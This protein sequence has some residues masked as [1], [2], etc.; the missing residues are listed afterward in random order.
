MKYDICIVGSGAGAAPVAYTLSEQ[1][2][3][4]AVLEK[5]P[6]LREEDFV[7]DEIAITRRPLYTPRLSEE[8]HVVETYNEAG[9]IE[10]VTGEESGWNFWNGSMV[11]GSSN[12]MS[13]YFHRM[14]PADFRLKSEYGS[15]EGANVVDWP[16]SYEEMEPYYTKVEAVVGVSGRVVPHP[17]LEPRSTK[18]FP[19]EPTWEQP[20]SRWF[21]EACGTLGFSALP[22]PRAVLPRDAL[23]RSGCSY[24]NYCGSYGCATGAKG[25]ARAA[26]LEKALKNGNC[27]I[28]PDA[29]V[30]RLD[31][32]S[33][34]RV[35][36][37]RYYDKKGVPHAV[38]ARLFVVAA[39]AIESA[40]L[41]LNSKSPAFPDG[42]A[43][44]SGQ[45]GKNLIF[46]AGG[47]GSGRFHLK[48]LSPE[49]QKGLMQRGAFVNR[50]LQDWYAFD[51]KGKRIKGGTIDFL[52]EH[53]NPINRALGE[54]YDEEGNMLWGETL[55]KR[56]KHAFTQSR[57]FTFEVFN[58][59][60]P[61][62]KCFVTVDEDVKDKRGVPV[63]RIRLH[64]HEHDL[65]VGRYLAAKAEAVLRE[66]GAV[67]IVSDISDAPPP[68]LVAGGCRFGTDP[69]HSV[70]RPDCRAHEVEN[71][72]VTDASFMPTGGS[73][74]YTWTIYAN[75]FRVADM[76]ARELKAH[77]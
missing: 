30:Y 45:V 22:T 65:E 56:I 63:G 35:T 23:G 10:R 64:A 26:L 34:K 74:P 17:F 59:W 14:K 19:Y 6:H 13:G 3:R 66:M 42:L 49:R 69:E 57:V 31:S 7:K 77:V 16:I 39:Q 37:A 46:S 54:L 18:D 73:V 27:T 33:R 76:I 38:E 25:S 51:F 50:S 47:S 32:D 61:T 12:L 60:L 15:I 44:N 2:Y 28:I 8:Q 21:D 67:E 11:G 71:L 43:N 55:Q 40:R 58:D 29:F 41:L 62:D 24:S 5:G 9:G 1:G 75:A 53:A 4:V 68:N 48:E 20:V 52:Y 72:Y 36:R 70:L